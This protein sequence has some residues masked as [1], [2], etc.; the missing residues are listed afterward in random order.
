MAKAIDLVRSGAGT[1]IHSLVV[2]IFALIFTIYYRPSGVYEHLTMQIASFT[3][4]VTILF[5][6]ILVSFSITRGWL[7]LLGKYKE[8]TGKVYLVW[9]L[10]EMLIAALFCSLYIFL[11]ED[12]GVSYFEVAGYTFINLLAICA[13]P[14]GFLWLGAEI[15]ARV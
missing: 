2:P 15:F 8:V 13:Y 9:S 6:I 3:F 12:Y 5:C 1:I 14:F 10:G 4:N 11:M 7:Y